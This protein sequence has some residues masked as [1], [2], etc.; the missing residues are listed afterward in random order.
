MLDD[1]VTIA[2]MGYAAL[3]LASVL[4]TI[5]FS[6]LVKVKISAHISMCPLKV[7]SLSV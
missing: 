5:S 4:G 6:P 1:S 3:S 2:V 7:E